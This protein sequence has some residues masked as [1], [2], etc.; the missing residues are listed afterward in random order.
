MHPSHE[1][2][3]QSI[4]R[5]AACRAV[6]AGEMSSRD[7]RRLLQD[8]ERQ[9]AAARRAERRARRKLGHDRPQQLAFE[10]RR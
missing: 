9:L 8:L 4:G 6:A 3:C 10:L 2:P 1:S 5:E 7:G